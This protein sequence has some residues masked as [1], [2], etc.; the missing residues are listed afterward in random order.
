MSGHDHKPRHYVLH[1]FDSPKPPNIGDFGDPP[2]WRLVNSAYNH[3]L[4]PPNQVIKPR[5]GGA[6]KPSAQPW[7]HGHL[8]SQPCRG[9]AACAALTGLIPGSV[10]RSQGCAL[11]FAARPLQ[12]PNWTPYLVSVAKFPFVPKSS[13]D[14]TNHGR[15]GF[16]PY[17]V[18]VNEGSVLL[19]THHLNNK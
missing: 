11:G 16:S 12:G 4:V 18:R 8:G 15:A 17:P 14:Q 19:S 3:L 1:H 6:A 10:G 2:E 7:D 9:D 13:V 5:R